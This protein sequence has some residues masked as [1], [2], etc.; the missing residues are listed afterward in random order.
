M[1]A[2]DI[3]LQILFFQ[4]YQLDLPGS[5]INGEDQPS[6]YH[7]KAGESEA[8]ECAVCLTKI[9]EG[10][11]IREPRCNHIFHRVC[12]DR[13]MCSYGHT[14]CPLCRDSLVPRRAITDLGH[15]VLVFKFSFTTADDG[16]D[17]WWLR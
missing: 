14:S 1:R 11:E 9:E 4:N 6:I 16:R 2:L 10:E 17:K 13:W 12:L 15:Q 5:K 7:H 8:T 3:L